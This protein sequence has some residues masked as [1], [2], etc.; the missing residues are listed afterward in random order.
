MPSLSSSF[1][2][3]LS[4]TGLVIRVLV[5]EGDQAPQVPLVDAES[6]LSRLSPARPAPLG[7]LSQQGLGEKSQPHECPVGLLLSLRP[8][9][10]ANTSPRVAAQAPLCCSGTSC[11]M[12]NLQSKESKTPRLPMAP[13]SDATA[14]KGGTTGETLGLRSKLSPSSNASITCSPRPYCPPCTPGLWIISDF[15]REGNL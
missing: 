13:Q 1:I 2:S 3:L 5:P 8:S 12:G 14:P 15:M 11:R 9:H 7:G 10:L 4:I 6:S